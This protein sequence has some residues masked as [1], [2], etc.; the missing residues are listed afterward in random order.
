LCTIIGFVI[1]CFSGAF[2]SCGQS[3]NVERSDAENW[4]LALVSRMNSLGLE[5]QESGI[6]GGHERTIDYSS[7]PT[8]PRAP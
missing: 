5:R 6:S 8:L 2:L 7:A 1:G 3:R 4:L